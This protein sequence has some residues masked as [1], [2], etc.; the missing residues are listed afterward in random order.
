MRAEQKVLRFQPP[1]YAKDRNNMKRNK[2]GT[3]EGTNANAEEVLINYIRDKAIS[4][5]G[6]L[7]F[8]L[9]QLYQRIHEKGGD[10]NQVPYIKL[11]NCSI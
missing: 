10:G 5:I 8:T 11:L 1:L 3:E 9:S 6:E 2:R 4:E 7:Q